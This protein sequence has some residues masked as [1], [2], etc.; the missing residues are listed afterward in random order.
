MA[1]NPFA[2]RPNSRSI[3]PSHNDWAPNNSF[4]RLGFETILPTSY[5]KPGIPL[6]RPSR[7][8]LCI[9]DGLGV[10][11]GANRGHGSTEGNMTHRNTP[12]VG[13]SPLLG[14]CGPMANR[15]HRRD[16]DRC[17][18]K[19]RPNAARIRA[20]PGLQFPVLVS[21]RLLG[22]GLQLRPNPSSSRCRGLLG[23]DLPILNACHMPGEGLSWQPPKPC[24]PS[25]C[26]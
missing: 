4:N 20:W 15:V 19:S 11:Y 26:G 17:S 25:Q 7:D 6:R 8:G 24:I 13:F 21:I 18:H 1:L 14:G 5:F 3:I 23:R 9:E 12:K 16:P 10:G 2:S 22:C